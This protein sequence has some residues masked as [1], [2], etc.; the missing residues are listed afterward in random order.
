MSSNDWLLT[1][2][3]YETNGDYEELTKTKEQADKPT[4]ARG[5]GR[6]R[7]IG[8]EA[9]PE[10]V[11][12]LVA[13][14]IASWFLRADNHF[15]LTDRPTRKYSYDDV[16]RICLRRLP[17]EFSDLELKPEQVSAALKLAVSEK[18]S[19][20]ETSIG[21][22]D[23]SSVCLP[24][25][26]DR[27]IARDGIC[28][29]NTWTTPSYRK[30]SVD[31][32]DSSLLDELLE[33]MF[34]HPEDRRV[35]MDWLAWCLQNEADKPGWAIFLYSRSKGTGK[36]TLC[37][38]V[39]R[40]F[41]LENSISQNSIEKLTGKFNHTILTSKLVVS[42]ELRLKP[43]SVQGNTLKTYITEKLTASEKKGREVER[44]EQSCCF[45]FTSNHY[46]FWIEAGDRRY[47]VIDCDH[48]GH[49][50]GPGAEKFGE[51]VGRVLD[52]LQDDRQIALIY[53]ALLARKLSNDF[54]PRS[55][56]LARVETP[57]M[58]ELRE[59]SRDVQLE[60]LEQFLNARGLVAVSLE[61]LD[62]IFT[63]HLKTNPNRI[64]YFM[65]DLGW[66]QA[67]GKCGGVDHSR[68]VYLKPGYQLSKGRIV[69]AD[70]YDEKFGPAVES[71]GQELFLEGG[72]D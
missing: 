37:H 63:R 66:R 50:S 31:K 32:A 28:Q 55:L 43:D 22:W 69:G 53:N 21:V 64:R 25:N 24:G 47:Y 59:G 12:P 51:L 72:I 71:A 16:V 9:E 57:L 61:D 19:N 27:I 44:L 70:G 1:N 52:A 17:N 54:D 3:D 13:R 60:R 34:P 46:P 41:G 10:D 26:D 35:F 2:I 62:T 5:L 42:E 67:K 33:Q 65:Q 7:K 45:L 18:T 20:T 49:S 48:Q 4:R 29:I 15:Y 8:R 68:V 11:V 6:F 58:L 39:S 23:G 30:L 40:L 36:S 56:N 38:L 14:T